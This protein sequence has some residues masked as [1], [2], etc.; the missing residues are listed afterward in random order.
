[1]SWQTDKEPIDYLRQ[2]IKYYKGKISNAKNWIKNP[3]MVEKYGDELPYIIG[4]SILKNESY[5]YV[6][7]KAVR[8]L[9]E[10][11]KEEENEGT[12]I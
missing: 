9:E 3:I 6:Y 12:K 8:D 11:E 4:R 5:L 1:M 7:V 10:I 2:R